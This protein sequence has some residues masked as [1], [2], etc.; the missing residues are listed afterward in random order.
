ME[1]A[2]VCSLSSPASCIWTEYTLLVRKADW[3]SFLP[4]R[5]HY[6]Q[7]TVCYSRL[8]PKTD[9]NPGLLQESIQIYFQTRS[10]PRPKIS[11]PRHCNRVLAPSPRLTLINMV[12]SSNPL[13]R[14]VDYL[15]RRTMAQGR[16][17]GHVGA[18]GRIHDQ[19]S[20]R[21]DDGLVERGWS[22]AGRVGWFCHFCQGEEGRRQHGYWVKFPESREDKKERNCKACGIPEF[23]SLNHFFCDIPIP[24]T[25]TTDE[26]HKLCEKS[27]SGQEL[28][29]RY[30]DLLTITYSSSSEFTGRQGSQDVLF[31][32]LFLFFQKSRT[33]ARRDE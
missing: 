23:L 9:H 14:L 31:L 7:T 32:L 1:E 10:R 13:A 2:P 33:R 19:V 25:M 21:P 5:W 27:V 3:L 17:Q 15:P 22:L 18:D 20:G 28:V 4:Q 26:S 11:S 12:V 24:A 29:F 30:S 6:L 8:P 16:E